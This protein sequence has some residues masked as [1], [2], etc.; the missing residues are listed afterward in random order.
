MSL[1]IAGTAFIFVLAV[2]TLFAQESAPANPPVQAP[3]AVPQATPRPPM[4]MNRWPNSAMGRRQAGPVNPPSLQQRVED[5]AA[6]LDKMHL[7]LKKMHTKAA[8]NA[9]DP[10][11]KA[12]L[13]MWDLMVGQ[14]D[15]QLQE[16]K[17]AETSRQEMEARRAAMYKQ[18]DVK[19]QA[20][21]RAAQ[22]G[23]FSQRAN[24]ADSA[25]SARPGSAAP[26][27]AASQTPAG[28]AAPN[29]PTSPNN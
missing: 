1:R 29:T 21:A 13:E 12:N 18:A 22:E 11:V 17:Q 7:V 8:A 23:K 20:E 14:L 27:P 4:P 24:P 5:L 3:A 15:K 6:T 19:A 25:Q 10:A 26:A 16:L 2:T 28:S 9:K